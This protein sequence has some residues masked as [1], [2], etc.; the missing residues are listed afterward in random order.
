VTT[1]DTAKPLTI[2]LGRSRPLEVSVRFFDADSIDANTN[3]L[4]GSP[5]AWFE[6]GE[7]AQASAPGDPFEQCTLSNEGGGDVQ[8]TVPASS[9]SSVARVSVFGIW[10]DETSMEFKS[11]TWV[12]SVNPAA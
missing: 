11:K 5:D 1:I 9:L 10:V 4:T 6:C 12:F 3:E 8:V 7:D 2:E